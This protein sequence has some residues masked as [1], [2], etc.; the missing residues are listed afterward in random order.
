M[1][2]PTTPKDNGGK[3]RPPVGARTAG[4]RLSQKGLRPYAGATGGQAGQSEEMTVLDA[5]LQLISGHAVEK[6][7]SG[8]RLGGR[9]KGL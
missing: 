4:L 7:L 6:S 8:F 9:F 5:N 1:A 2:H 3:T